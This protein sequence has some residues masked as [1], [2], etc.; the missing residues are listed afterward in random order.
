MKPEIW[1][2]ATWTLLHS[3]TLAYPE[4]PTTED[5]ENIKNFINS[6]GKVIP[7]EK[8]RINFKS[9]TE[10][11]PLNDDVLN[12]RKNFIK[13]MI[14]IHNSVNKMNGKKVLTY[15]DALKNILMTY[16][17]NN[18]INSNWSTNKNI[19][20]ITLTIIIVILVIVLFYQNYQNYQW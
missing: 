9:H 6:F 12:S 1:G 17:N 11:I 13:W 10:E 20:I 16:N 19:I 3:I 8:C 18:S 5:K 4:S 2:P 15:H 7:C 14:D